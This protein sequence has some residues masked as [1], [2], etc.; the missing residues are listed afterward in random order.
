MS[1]VP[2]SQ[3]PPQ[4]WRPFFSGKNSL[5]QRT[6]KLGA[7]RNLGAFF[8]WRKKTALSTP[9]SRSGLSK[10]CGSSSMLRYQ[11]EYAKSYSGEAYGARVECKQF[12]SRELRNCE[13]KGPLSRLFVCI[14]RY[15]CIQIMEFDPKWVHMA[16]HD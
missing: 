13:L 1:N 12:V 15:F 10:G 5:E 7:S 16:R 14:L 6:H 11:C 3:G 9:V 2:R 4:I 8:F